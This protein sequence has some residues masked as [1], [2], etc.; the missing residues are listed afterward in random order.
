MT[1]VLSKNLFGQEVW[2]STESAGAFRRHGGFDVPALCLIEYLATKTPGAVAADIGANVGN[3]T[4]VLAKFCARVTCFEPRLNI[5][6]TLRKNVSHNALTNCTLVAAGLSD[7]ADVAPLYLGDNA[8]GGSTTF[9]HGLTSGTRESVDAPLLV[10]DEYFSQSGI[11]R[12]DIVKLDVEGMEANVVLGM[13]NTIKKYQPIFLMEWNN[14]VTRRNFAEKSIFDTIFQ[15]YTLI[16]VRGKDA[17]ELFSKNVMGWVGRKLARIAGTRG[18]VAVPFERESNFET[19]VLM[20][21]AKAK[22][23]EKLSISS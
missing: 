16:G 5:E 11:D 7:K 2:I 18:F 22:T 20:P 21:R 1:M 15:N 14:D 4:V 8:E 23:F 19:L 3:H 13:K 9:V 17:R 10:G 6:D 12:L